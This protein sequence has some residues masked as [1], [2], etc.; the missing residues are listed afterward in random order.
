MC[1]ACAGHSFP[2]DWG[3]E[4][5]GRGPGEG[6]GTWHRPEALL[7]GL[8]R[9]TESKFLTLESYVFCQHP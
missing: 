8:Q 7:S 6:V 5:E 4:G 2:I 3:V 1:K 9:V